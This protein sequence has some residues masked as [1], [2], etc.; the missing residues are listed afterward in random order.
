MRRS[1]CNYMGKSPSFDE[2]FEVFHFRLK[3]Y[4]KF[5]VSRM[6]HGFLHV[7]YGE[8]AYRVERFPK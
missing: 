6:I 1:Y 8:L 2:D 7:F 5:F 4:E 3:F